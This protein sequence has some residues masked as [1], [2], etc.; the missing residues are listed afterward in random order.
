MEQV[1]PP[2]T[3]A[4]TVSCLQVA[5]HICP[6]ANQLTLCCAE[7]GRTHYEL[8]GRPWVISETPTKVSLLSEN[9]GWV[10]VSWTNSGT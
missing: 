9:V 6:P 10:V 1:Q 5:A 7:V 4:V 8:K 2:L 3:R